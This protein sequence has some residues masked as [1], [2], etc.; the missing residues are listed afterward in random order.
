MKEKLLIYKEFIK[1]NK[2]ASIVAITVFVIICVI[3]IGYFYNNAQRN[4]QIQYNIKQINERNEKLEKL[5]SEI[6]DTNNQIKDLGNS[7]KLVVINIEE[8]NYSGDYHDV[9][10]TLKN[11]SSSN[12]S[13]A[14]VD[15]YFKDDKGNIIQS[16]SVSTDATIK[17]DATQTVTKMI[18]ND[19][20]FKD[21]SAEVSKVE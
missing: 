3:G 5:Q 17:S 19:I 10:I 1:N 7:M 11:I 16:D 20:K 21:I 12:V 14:K 2:K 8:T 13:Y 4:E 6:E 9:N 15:L 18:K